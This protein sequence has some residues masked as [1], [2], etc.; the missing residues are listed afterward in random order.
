MYFKFSNSQSVTSILSNKL[1]FKTCIL[2]QNVTYCNKLTVQQNI[3]F[4][5][6][7]NLHA[8]VDTIIYSILLSIHCK[9]YHYQPGNPVYNTWRDLFTYVLLNVWNTI[10]YILQALIVFIYPMK[11]KPQTP[12]CANFV[13][14][15]FITRY[16][17]LFH[18]TENNSAYHLLI[19]NI[20]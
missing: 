15:Y 12:Y 9:A 10:S 13:Y 4:K 16:N 14:T 18:L 11:C 17:R 3:C 1:I 19:N 5:I 20:I 2:R 7:F 8:R 6:A